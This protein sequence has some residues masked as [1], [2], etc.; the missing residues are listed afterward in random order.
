MTLCCKTYPNFVEE[1]NPGYFILYTLLLSMKE[2]SSCKN[3]SRKEKKT[4]RLQQ[5]FYRDFIL[6]EQSSKPRYFTVYTLFLSMKKKQSSK[7]V[8]EK[9]STDISL[10]VNSLVCNKSVAS[11][12]V[13]HKS[14]I[15]GYLQQ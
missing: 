4:F 1:K 10:S 12:F 14:K 15:N 3:T 7:K 5:I 9:K 6:N 2:K 8:D 11:F 13:H